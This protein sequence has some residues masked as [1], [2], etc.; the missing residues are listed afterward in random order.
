MRFIHI[1]HKYIN[2]YL[3]IDQINCISLIKSTVNE[4][5]WYLSIDSLNRCFNLDF[6]DE[7]KAIDEFNDLIM[8]IEE[9]SQ[10]D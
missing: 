5:L 10:E 4:N 9:L 2:A 8:T 6:D 1:V 3:N 7:Q